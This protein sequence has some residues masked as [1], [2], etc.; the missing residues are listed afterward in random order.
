MGSLLAS[1]LLLAG[2]FVVMRYLLPRAG[3]QT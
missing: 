1:V 2:Y 3:V